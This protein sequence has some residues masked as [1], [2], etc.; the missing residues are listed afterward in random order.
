MLLV[1]LRGRVHF[2]FA[3]RLEVFTLV[4][5][6]WVASE[7]LMRASPTWKPLLGCNE[8]GIWHNTGTL[9]SGFQ[10]DSTLLECQNALVVRSTPG[11]F[12]LWQPSSGKC[13]WVLLTHV[14]STP[15][16]GFSTK[17]TH[18]A[19]PLD[20]RACAC[21]CALCLF[22]TGYPPTT[23]TC[24]VQLLVLLRVPTSPEDPLRA[25][26]RTKACVPLR[27]DPAS[28]LQPTQRIQG[29]VS[30]SWLRVWV[31][32]GQGVLVSDGSCA[33]ASPWDLSSGSPIAPEVRD[34]ISTLA[35]CGTPGPWIYYHSISTSACCR[36]GGRT[37]GPWIYRRTT[38]VSRPE[39]F[40]VDL[41]PG[42]AW[43]TR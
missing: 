42:Q 27:L 21:A 30:L 23:F 18:G 26:R 16:G 25:S 36:V 9:N 24:R 34:S 38:H 5:R 15:L 1:T 22:E 6:S 39:I 40:P 2:C 37:P 4:T 3:K 35:C 8:I 32:Q 14:T 31:N 41:A 13:P 29:Q 11:A 20:D 10:T 17:S 7:F 19:F 28:R 12:W 43:G 33:H